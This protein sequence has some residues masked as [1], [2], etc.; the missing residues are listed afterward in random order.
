M[1]P[2]QKSPEIEGHIMIKPVHTIAV[3]TL[4]TAIAGG[5]NASMQTFRLTLT[6]TG[7]QPLSPLFYSAG[8][9]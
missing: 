8:T 3:L 4:A 7:P 5:A 9:N 1:G 6:D 2:E